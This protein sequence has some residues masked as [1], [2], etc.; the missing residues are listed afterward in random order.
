MKRLLLL[1]GLFLLSGCEFFYLPSTYQYGVDDP[2]AEIGT[3]FRETGNNS[4]NISALMGVCQYLEAGLTNA[5]DSNSIIIVADFTD[6]SLRPSEYPEYKPFLLGDTG[7]FRNITGSWDY[8][9]CNWEFNPLSTTQTNY[10]KVSS[11]DPDIYYIKLR[12]VGGEPYLVDPLIASNTFVHFLI[13]N[14]LDTDNGKIALS[15]SIGQGN[16]WDTVGRQDKSGAQWYARL[17]FSG[18]ELN[19]MEKGW[20]PYHDTLFVHI[21]ED[22]GVY[23]SPQGKVM[24]V[25]VNQYHQD[26]SLQGSGS[27]DIPSGTQ[28]R[29]IWEN[30]SSTQLPYTYDL[31]SLEYVIWTDWPQNLAIG[32][33]VSALY[34]NGMT[35]SDDNNQDLSLAHARP[36]YI[37]LSQG[38]ASI[39]LTLSS[40]HSPSWVFKLLNSTGYRQGEEP[41]THPAFLPNTEGKPITIVV[42]AEFQTTNL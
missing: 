18:S 2:F 24:G 10:F 37:D 9:M 41:I 3:V 12:Y 6:S 33:S 25:K 4:S 30:I 21:P 11:L 31:F 13:A 29:I 8:D 34:D 40:S 39:D 38:K 32:G 22:K 17:R 35:W 20:K 5:G 15:S 26:W 19:I 16:Y 36:V 28:V 42:N 7:I 23:V 14:F 1:A 27:Y